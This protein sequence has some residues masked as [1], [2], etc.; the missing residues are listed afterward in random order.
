MNPVSSSEDIKPPLGLNGVLKVPAH[1]SGNMASFTKHICAICG[2]RSSGRPRGHSGDGRAPGQ[3]GA[4]RS[5]E[6][7]TR[8]LLVC[9]R[10]GGGKRQRGFEASRDE[11]AVVVT[12]AWGQQGCARGEGP[13]ASHSRARSPGGRTADLLGPP[14]QTRRRRGPRGPGLGWGRDAALLRSQ[15]GSLTPVGRAPSASWPQAAH[16]RPTCRQ[17]LW[18]VQLRGLQG[19]LQADG[20]QGPDLHLPRQQRLPD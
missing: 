11:A 9:P 15:A 1:P 10:P 20:A 12:M 7:R 14:S 18:G 19:L 8:D 3:Q 13:F 17:A 5:S 4:A 2:D 6:P 16:G